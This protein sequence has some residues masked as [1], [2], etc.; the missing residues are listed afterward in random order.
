MSAPY[1]VKVT[2]RAIY[3]PLC[4]CIA[5]TVTEAASAIVEGK[6]LRDDK[7]VDWMPSAQQFLRR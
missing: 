7:E 4:I 5:G 2:L 6:R 1:A 3:D